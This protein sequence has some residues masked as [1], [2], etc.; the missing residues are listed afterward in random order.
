SFRMRGDGDVRTVESPAAGS[1]PQAPKSGPRRPGDAAPA[2]G[3]SGV[4]LVPMDSEHDSNVRIDPDGSDV[5]TNVGDKPASSRDSDIRLEPSQGPKSGVRA[6]PRSPEDSVL[7]EEI[8]LDAELSRA[9]KEARARPQ[10]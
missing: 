5:G 8:D 4:R 2:K 7:T 10:E 6:G 1:R 3:D 9:E